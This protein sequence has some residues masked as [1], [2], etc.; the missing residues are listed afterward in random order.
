[1][2]INGPMSTLFTYES[3]QN[4]HGIVACRIGGIFMDIWWDPCWRYLP[5]SCE[6]MSVADTQPYHPRPW[7]IKLS[8]I[9]ERLRL[10]SYP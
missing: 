2:P 7:I 6:T 5:V 10:K 4:I 8:K 3:K 1:M 9:P